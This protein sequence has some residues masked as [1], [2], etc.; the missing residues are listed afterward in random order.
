MLNKLNGSCFFFYL[1]GEN[2][3]VV[4]IFQNVNRIRAAKRKKR[5]DDVS[6]IN[7]KNETFHDDGFHDIYFQIEPLVVGFQSACCCPVKKE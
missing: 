7:E 4:K 3:T 6:G 1:N 2:G 5:A